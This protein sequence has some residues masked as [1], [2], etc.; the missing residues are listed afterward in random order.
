VFRVPAPEVEAVIGRFLRDHCRDQQTGLRSLVEAQIAK[1]IIEEDSISVELAAPTGSPM[2]PAQTVSLP[3]S[4]KPFRLAKGIATEP[5]IPGIS[6]DFDSKAR[7]AVLTA[8]NHARR[9]VDQLVTGT[10]LPEIAIQEGKSPRY[11]RLLTS[12]AFIPP[13]LMSEIVN[14]ERRYTATELAGHMPLLW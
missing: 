8:I 2:S 9:W 13:R 10:P 3:W 1:I 7:E 6:A 14:G 11:I 12:L 4:K 5:P